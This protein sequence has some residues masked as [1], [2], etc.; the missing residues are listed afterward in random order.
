MDTAA[1]LP[2]PTPPAEVTVYTPE[3]ELLSPRR[4]LRSM[5]HDLLA[6]RELAWRLAV[7]DISARYRQ[8]LLGVFWAFLGPLLNTA[9]FVY[10][11]RNKILASGYQGPVPYDIF[12]MSGVM[13][14][15]LFTTCLTVPMQAVA[16]GSAMLAKVNFPREALL[17]SAIAKLLF[18]FG[19]Q[20]LLLAG[21][22]AFHMLVPSW[23]SVSLPGWGVVFAPLGILVLMLFGLV[24]G[25]LIMPLN[26][27]YAD[28]T[29]VVALVVGLGFFMTPVVYEKRE[30]TKVLGALVE[31]NPVGVLLNT[32]R[33]LL[34]T[35]TMS[36][37]EPF[38][39][40][41]AGI[42]LVGFLLMWVLYRVSLPILI[43][44]MSA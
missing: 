41:L 37:P 14:W 4:L 36:G 38:A 39:F 15:T 27:L 3:S 2:G 25:L 35:G 23:G 29:N 11:H 34:T 32:S 5:W 26:V 7:R 33:D 31:W 40:I 28:V 12:V 19:V 42:T 21:L 17:L 1:E 13:L 20:L 18:D 44:R 43:E 22:F 30:A 9:V 24:I 8:S 10:L 16:G 6:S